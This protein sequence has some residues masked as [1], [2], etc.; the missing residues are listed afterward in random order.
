VH[1]MDEEMLRIQTAPAR[2]LSRC[3]DACPEGTGWLWDADVP[4][5]PRLLGG[6][7]IVPI[8]FSKKGK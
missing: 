2:I 8:V 3:P 6:V 5:I 1:R 4:V 7:P